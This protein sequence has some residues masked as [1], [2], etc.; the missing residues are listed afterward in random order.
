MTE[1]KWSVESDMLRAQ[2]TYNYNQ[3]CLVLQ[4][5]ENIEG[6]LTDALERLS[7][8]DVTLSNMAIETHRKIENL[9]AAIKLNCEQLNKDCR[10]RE[11]EEGSERKTLGRCN[12]PD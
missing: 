2:N 5:L 11:R 9:G 3:N 7:G 8:H 12:G 4:R 10:F 1:A 6:K